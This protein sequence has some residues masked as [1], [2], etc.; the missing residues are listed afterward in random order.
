[1]VVLHWRGDCVRLCGGWQNFMLA[2][3]YHKEKDWSGGWWSQYAFMHFGADCRHKPS[4][5]FSRPADPGRWWKQWPHCSFCSCQLPTKPG[6]PQRAV[7]AV[8]GGCCRSW[9]R[10]W[11]GLEPAPDARFYTLV[12]HGFLSAAFSIE[13]EIRFEDRVCLFSLVM[14]TLILANKYFKCCNCTTEPM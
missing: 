7:A 14:G 2:S 10:C 3:V 8:G 11:E 1:M 4:R 12:I 5:E 6:R 9:Y 13:A